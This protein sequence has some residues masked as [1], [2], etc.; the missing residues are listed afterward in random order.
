MM[1]TTIIRCTPACTPACCRFR[2]AVMKNAV[3]ACCSGEG[4]V[5]VSMTHSTPAKAAARPSPVITSTPCERDIG[6]TSYPRAMSTSA[7]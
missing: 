1:D 5:A 6:T 4:P 7:T 2:A 3:A